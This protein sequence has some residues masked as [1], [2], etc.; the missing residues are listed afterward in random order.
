[1]YNFYLK[2]FEVWYALATYFNTPFVYTRFAASPQ[3]F[4]NPYTEM[5][6]MDGN[7]LHGKGLD[8]LL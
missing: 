8:F 4:R 6:G 2:R 7:K 1:M 5:P 3:W